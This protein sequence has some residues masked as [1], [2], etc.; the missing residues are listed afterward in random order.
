MGISGPYLDFRKT[1]HRFSLQADRTWA[2]VVFPIKEK[3][4]KVEERL[5]KSNIFLRAYFH[6]SLKKIPYVDHASCKALKSILSRILSLPLFH[7][8]STQEETQ[9]SDSIKNIA[10]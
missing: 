8:P 3:V 2:S 1:R 10:L 7:N 4:M 6:P 5:R 9:L